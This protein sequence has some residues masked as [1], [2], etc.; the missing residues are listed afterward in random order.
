[1]NNMNN[2]NI[3]NNTVIEYLIDMI[4]E[5]NICIKFI[6]IKEINKK[7]KKNIADNQNRENNNV[8]N[9]NY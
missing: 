1:M 3:N 8:L 7:I 9:K 6:K 4:N 2:N 5:N